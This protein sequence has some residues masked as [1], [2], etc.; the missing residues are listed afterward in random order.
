MLSKIS[1][2]KYAGSNAECYISHNNRLEKF[3]GEKKQTANSMTGET[4]EIQTTYL[5]N[6][7]HSWSIRNLQ[8]QSQLY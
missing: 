8:A 1:T 5:D 7:A 2:Y 6:I 3:T 4:V